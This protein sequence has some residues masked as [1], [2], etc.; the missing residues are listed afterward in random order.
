MPDPAFVSYVVHFGVFEA[1]LRSG[2]LR[3][4]GLK[5]KIQE[6]PFRVLAMLLERPGHIVARE[7]LRKKLWPAETFVDFEHGLNAAINKLREALGDSADNPRFVETLPRRGY[8]FIAPVEARHALAPSSETGEVGIESPPGLGRGESVVPGS[9]AS[10]GMTP[11]SERAEALVEAGPAPVSPPAPV[12]AVSDRR[13]ETAVREQRHK[14]RHW[15]LSLGVGALALAGVVALLVGLNVAHWR[16]RLLTALGGRGS[17][18]SPRIESIA[19]LPFDNLSNDPEQ[20]YFADGMTE[21]LITNLGKVSALRVISRTSVMRFKGTRKPLP[22]IAKELNVDAIVEGT[23]LRSGNRVRITANL[24]HAPTD[25]HLWAESYE[26]DLGDVLSLQREVASAIAREVQAKLTPQEQDRLATGHS[27]NPEVYEAYIRGRRSLETRTKAGIENSIAYFQKAIALDP[28][29]AILNAGLADAFSVQGDLYYIPPKE[30]YPRAKAAAAKALALD[31]N[32]AEAY[33]S[34]CHIT[35]RFDWDWPAAERDCTRAVELN[36][37]SAS[38]LASASDYFIAMGRFEEGLALSRRYVER[39]PL[40]PASHNLLGWNYYE[41]RRYDE[42]IAECK[43]ALELDPNYLSSWEGL[44][45]A[46]LEKRMY[47]EA[48]AAYRAYGKYIA[49]GSH[50]ALTD[51][52][53]AYARAGARDQA[54]EVLA[55]LRRL[56]K[57]QHVPPGAFAWVY[58]G[59]GDKDQAFLWLA[60]ALEEREP[61]GFPWA[62]VTPAWDPLRSDPRFQDLLHRMNFPP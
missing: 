30:A 22:E 46:Y 37:N 48:I 53:N 21:E 35:F 4:H 17:M 45:Q 15:T 25:R 56:S 52:G 27:L 62:K 43:K 1:D 59:L 23:V 57:R 3:K 20:E 55:E 40:S 34:L 47:P 58:T 5:V 13:K 29:G 39:D 44:G 50:E 10:P 49:P 38:A 11:R 26:R 6:Q 60:K 54:L 33:A 51:L 36:P 7:E 28:T 32:L 12:A 61:S 16:D 41:S 14:V 18:P 2:E 8:R 31:P 9:A 19:I 24:L 42:A